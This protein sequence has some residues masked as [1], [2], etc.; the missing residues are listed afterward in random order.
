VFSVK[1]V[2]GKFLMVL[3]AACAFGAL[4][5]ASAF[6]SPEW[7]LNG[8]KLTESIAT[9]SSGELKMEAFDGSATEEWTCK[10]SGAGTV[11]TAGKSTVTE[12]KLTSCK[13]ADHGIEACEEGKPVT[14]TAANLPWAGQLS[15]S[16]SPVANVFG[17][18]AGWKWECPFAV[19]H[20][21]KWLVEC[22]G[23]VEDK[24][25]SESGFVSEDFEGRFGGANPRCKRFLVIAGKRNEVKAEGEQESG[26]SGHLDVKSTSGT[27]SAH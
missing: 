5:S 16:M 3:L 8:N 2:L 24:I 11:G 25:L 10:V 4:A 7:Y 27:I 19:I 23:T 22:T 14:V 15:Y 12:Q 17:A 1:P 13:Y 21:D 18:K 20:E 26:V 9:T 6:A